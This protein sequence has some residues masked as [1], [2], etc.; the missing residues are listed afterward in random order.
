MLLLANQLDSDVSS[1]LSERADAQ[2]AA[3]GRAGGRTVAR[4]S[5][6]QGGLGEQSWVFDN[7]GRELLRPPASSEVEHAAR[8]LARV[9]HATEVDVGDNVR[10]RA[11]PARRATA[12][13]IGTVVVGQS[14]GPYDHTEHLALLAMLI[15]DA[16]ILALGVVVARR[17]VGK[18]LQ[19]VADM[20]AAQANDWSEHH[21][22]RRFN[23]G[24]PGDG[25]RPVRDAGPPARA[26]RVEPSPRAA[27]LRGDGA[28]ASNTAQHGLAAGRARAARARRLSDTRRSLETDPARHRPHAGVIETLLVAA[29]REEP[30][31]RT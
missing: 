11:E 14:L 13:R 2:L 27:L 16:C 26:D 18:A 9:G 12:G 7:G 20:T 30:G 31:R 22:D 25:Y 29:R 5:P 23:R 15:L 8:R 21:L 28:R 10:L 19:P 3:L 6:E 1:T 4:P 17:V 24:P